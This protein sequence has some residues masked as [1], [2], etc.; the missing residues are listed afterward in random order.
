MLAR[1]GR[2]FCSPRYSHQCRQLGSLSR[3]V[4]TG[5]QTARGK[6][7][8]GRETEETPR[9]IRWRQHVSVTLPV[10]RC[11]GGL[12]YVAGY[13]AGVNYLFIELVFFNSSN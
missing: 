13:T 10:G 9:S 5:R 12:L 6:S 8:G 3:M 11:A 2:P 7:V 4:A 1:C